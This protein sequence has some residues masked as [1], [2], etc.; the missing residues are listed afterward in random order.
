MDLGYVNPRVNVNQSFFWFLFF[1]LFKSFGTA[2]V[3]WN[4][5]QIK[6]YDN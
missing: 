6:K 2:Y 1:A 3:V 4:Y 5:S